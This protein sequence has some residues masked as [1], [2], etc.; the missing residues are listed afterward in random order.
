MVSFREIIERTVDPQY[1]TVGYRYYTE[2]RVRKL[3][4]EETW[5][6]A[7]VV[8][9]VEYNVLIDFNE[10]LT[11]IHYQCTCPIVDKI[12]PHITAV[13]Y[14]LNHLGFFQSTYYIAQINN[15]YRVKNS[16][17]KRP[18][19][20][21]HSARKE[22]SQAEKEEKL[23]EEKLQKRLELEKK[24]AEEEQQRKKEKEIAEFYS[25][26]QVFIPQK[27]AKKKSKK[28]ELHTIISVEIIILYQVCFFKPVRLVMRPD[29]SI[30]HTVDIKGR[31]YLDGSSANE[32][33]ILLC[34]TLL[35]A[36]KNSKIVLSEHPDFA[37][38]KETLAFSKLISGIMKRFHDR[39]WIMEK[40]NNGEKSALN[41]IL[42]PAHLQFDL[43]KGDNSLLLSGFFNHENFGRIDLNDIT[44]ILPEPFWFLHNNAIYHC[45][46]ITY[47]QYQVLWLSNNQFKIP[48]HHAALVEKNLFPHLDP[49]IQI[50]SELYEIHD[51]AT[52][53]QKRLYF[54]KMEGS[55][56][57]ALK[58]RYDRYEIPAELKTPYI[59]KIE[60]NKLIRIRRDDIVED[61][62]LKFMRQFDLRES[63]DGYFIP[64]SD[65]FQ[66]LGEILPLLSEAGFEVFGEDGVN[67]IVELAD[68]PSLTANVVSGINWFEL[69]AYASF[70]GQSVK[71]S[72][73]LDLVRKK[74]KY[75]LLNNGL[76]A[77]L[78]DKWLRKF[79]G[80]ALFGMEE[81][82][83]MRFSTAQFMALEN[84]LEE[85]DSVESDDEY[86]QKLENLRSFEKIDDHPLPQGLKAHL[87]SYQKH[88]F[89][90]FYFLQQY[91]FGGILADD[92][93]LGKTLQVLALLL[94]EKTRGK[95]T[96][97]VIAPTS[98]IFN[99]VNEVKKFTPSLKALNYTGTERKDTT[100]T[101]ME[102]YDVILTSYAIALRDADILSQKTF[103]YIILDE[104]QKIKN[105]F[106]KTAKAI[107]TLNSE[108]RLCLTGTPVENNL[109]ELWSQVSFLNPGMLGSLLRF[110]E[111]FIKQIQRDNSS[112][113]VDQLKKMIYP[114]ILRRTKE[115]VAKE[116]P[117]KTEIIHY[118]EMSEL[119]ANLYYEVRD[120]IHKSLMKKI[121]KDGIK[122]SQ[123]HILDG[124]L[125][126]RQICNHPA[127]VKKDT[128]YESG[129]FEEFKDLL[130]KVVSEK[131]KVLVFSQFVQMLDIIKHFLDLSKIKFT[132]LTGETRNREECVRQ[133][134]EDEETR[135]FLISLKAGG[136]GL[137]LTAADYVFH[138]DPWWNPAV[139]EQATD[140]THRIGQTK[141]VFIY[142]FITRNSVEEKILHLQKKKRE[143]VENI[144]T[145]ESGLLKEISKEDINHLFS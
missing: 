128:I 81:A 96:S 43:Q 127:L 20:K 90:W 83:K 2:N 78:P 130:I 7:S 17:R 136:F 141:N 142:K 38:S 144:I 125:R 93:G 109:M 47:K 35:Y 11:P 85:A 3:S 76:I 6:H 92:M 71:L 131:H 15:A 104:S 129:K 84:L 10:T 67:R 8:S 29:G 9:D 62:A 114:F 57:F 89:D 143:L 113:S 24:W 27:P 19:L 79:Q 54:E 86:R 56:G 124:L 4:L 107:K 82:D 63:R 117:P 59:T 98:V 106:S 23:K 122:K 99:W 80:A 22:E 25:R 137:N 120:A 28:S 21:K 119:Q 108:F 102:E 69:D 115:V 49:A 64:R 139:E 135:V 40:S 66:M 97:L 112:D 111:G 121:E 5:I 16:T 60:D 133:F 13:L 88:G 31:D 118:C 44:V 30:D 37:I 140:R 145:T 1:R 132:Y 95:F 12:C 53:P 65:P 134:Q 91:H 39:A 75:I 110:R 51:I 50:T 42:K 48:L 138:Y 87:R 77:K 74:K 33:E 126:L 105:P 58:F 103:R 101:E 72:E 116:L 52:T 73:I 94:N 68:S 61:E 123:I 100:I 32:D 55:M 34:E 36:H 45:E 26:M 18:T 41:I 46:S 14:Q 70:G